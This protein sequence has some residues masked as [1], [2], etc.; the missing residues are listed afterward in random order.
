MSAVVQASHINHSSNS[1]VISYGR[2]SINIDSCEVTYDNQIVP[3]NPKEYQLLLLFLRYPNHVL[4]YEVI[5]DKLWEASKY[6][7]QGNIRSHIKGL[8]K[9]FK[10]ID[11]SAQIVETVHG[12]GYR[13]K[14]LKKE[15]LTHP[16]ISPSLG[17]MKDFLKAKAIEYIV[18]DEK[19][20]IK[21]ISPNLADYCDY[22]ELLQVEIH[23]GEAFPEFIGLENVFQ[24]IINQ[25]CNNFEIK[26]IARAVNPNRPEYI[27]LYVVSNNVQDQSKLLFIFFEDASEQMIYKQRLVQLENETYLM[28]EFKSE[29]HN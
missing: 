3:L 29:D 25:E 13:L 27:N 8:R 21:Y 10:K 5:I 14:S 9:A 24:K 1:Q 6:P 18:I 4:S 7:T 26:G 23:A 19:F 17:V 2:I 11:E 20:I 12:L 22:P 15:K 16:I 28:L